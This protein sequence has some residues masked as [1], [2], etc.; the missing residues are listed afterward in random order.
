M[1]VVMSFQKLKAM[2]DSAVAD[3]D[4]AAIEAVGYF[5]QNNPSAE[6]VAKYIYDKLRA[7]LPDGVKL[8]NV[9]VIEEPGC[10][11]TFSQ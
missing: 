9:R 5:Q 4:N 11:A 10:S 6:N 8:R 2:L 3:F 7:G 1:G